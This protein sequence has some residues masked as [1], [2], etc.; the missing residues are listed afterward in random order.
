MVR[1]IVPELDRTLIFDLSSLGHSVSCSNRY[2][3]MN[4]FLVN[5]GVLAS[6]TDSMVCFYVPGEK[7]GI[8]VISH[9]VCF[10]YR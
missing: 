9:L 8:S 7:L 2:D 5:V 10:R 6:N 1:V 4:T 3:F